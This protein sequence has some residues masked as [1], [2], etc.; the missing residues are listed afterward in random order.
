MAI[1]SRSMDSDPINDIRTIIGNHYNSNS[2]LKELI[3]NARDAGASTFYFKAIKGNTNADHELLKLDALLVFND[4]EFSDEDAAKITNIGSTHKLNSKSNVG[5]YGLG[6][7][8]IFHYCDAFFY[9]CKTETAIVNPWKSKHAKTHQDWDTATEKDDDFLNKLFISCQEATKTESDKG[10][11]LFIPLRNNSYNHYISKNKVEIESLWQPFDSVLFKKSL[12][13]ILGVLPCTIESNLNKIIIDT[14][15]IK[16]TIE[17]NSISK[18]HNI[19]SVNQNEDVY[20]VYFSTYEE[21]IYPRLKE[22]KET[23]KLP[24]KTEYDEETDTEKMF[25]PYKELQSPTFVALLHKNKTTIGTTRFQ[26]CCYLPL[27]DN[28]QI[29]KYKNSSEYDCDIFI[30][31]EFETDGGRKKLLGLDFSKDRIS[32]PVNQI[33][34]NLKEDEAQYWWNISLVQELLSEYL[35]T[36]LENDVLAYVKKNDSIVFNYQNFISDVFYKNSELIIP[37]YFLYKVYNKNE[38]Q[39]N[40]KNIEEIDEFY[41]E[42][43]KIIQDK[44]VSKCSIKE[45]YNC[46]KEYIFNNEKYFSLL[47]LKKTL[48]TT[49]ITFNSLF[50]EE[51]LLHLID[52]IL[53]KRIPIIFSPD[54]EIKLVLNNDTT[55]YLVEFFE[56]FKN[57]NSCECSDILN[58]FELNKEELLNLCK[59][60]NTY[61]ICQVHN[62]REKNP[63]KNEYLTYDTLTKICEKNGLYAGYLQNVDY[64]IHNLLNISESLD[65]YSISEKNILSKLFQD[66]EHKLLDVNKTVDIF[67][68]IMS[69]ESVNFTKDEILL[70]TFFSKIDSYNEN[71]PDYLS[72][73]KFIITN[74]RNKNG[75]LIYCDC[76]ESDLY[77]KLFSKSNSEKIFITKPIY[78]VLKQKNITIEKIDSFT[79]KTYLN[80]GIDFSIFTPDEKERFLLTLTGET[81]K[82][83]PLH[84]TT[85]NDYV[86]FTDFCYLIVD[87]TIK[88][89]TDYHNED[90]SFIK[91]SDNRELQERQ[92]EILRD[93]ILTETKALEILF[94][95]INLNLTDKEINAYLVSNINYADITILNLNDNFRNRKWIELSN[96]DFCSPNEIINLD[97][98]DKNISIKSIVG[99]VFTIEDISKDFQKLTNR[100]VFLENNDIA[101]DVL[102]CLHPRKIDIEEEQLLENWDIIKPFIQDKFYQLV[103]SIFENDKRKR[104]E[105]LLN[106]KY[107]VEG[108]FEDYANFITDLSNSKED[109]SILID[110]VHL[111]LEKEIVQE[112]LQSFLSVSTLKLP[113]EN[114]GWN[115]ANTISNKFN[116]SFSRKQQLNQS[117]IDVIEISEE[118]KAYV[119]QE[120]FET[121][122]ATEEN[123]KTFFTKIIESKNDIDP[124]L[125]GLFLFLLA[126]NYR[127]FAEN[128]GYFTDT[129]KS[130]LRENI[131]FYG[132]FTPEHWISKCSSVSDAI[133][134][135][136]N[137]HRFNVIL[138]VRKGK[139]IQTK[140]L[141]NSV[142]SVEITNNKEGD[143]LSEVN[144]QTP[145]NQT[146]RLVL[147]FLYNDLSEISSKQLKNAIQY[148]YKA[149]YYQRQL[150]DDFYEKLLVSEQASIECT[151]RGIFKEIFG[152]LKILKLKEYFSKEFDDYNE[153]NFS[154]HNND[155]Q[156][157]SDLQKKI[158]DK[159]N[160]A[161]KEKILSAV[162]KNLSDNQYDSTRILYE[163]LQ[164]ADDAVGQQID[165]LEKTGKDSKEVIRDF[166]IEKK[167]DTFIISHYGREINFRPSEQFPNSY[168]YDL[169]NMIQISNSDKPEQMN[170]TGKFGLGFKS[171]Y[172][173]CNQ[174]IIRSGRL[175]FQIIAGL[176]PEKCGLEKINKG[177]TRIE[178]KNDRSVSDLLSSFEK[179]IELSIIFSK[180][181]RGISLFGT[182]YLWSPTVTKINDNIRIEESETF[183]AIRMPD[184]ITLVFQNKENRIVPLADKY[185]KIWHTAPLVDE[186]KYLPYAVN[187]KF[188]VDTGRKSLAKGHKNDKLILDTADIIAESFVELYKQNVKNIGEMVSLILTSGLKSE[189]ILKPFA[190]KLC[191]RLYSLYG[192]IPDGYNGFASVTTTSR[193]FSISETCMENY[194]IESKYPELVGGLK[195]LLSSQ[196]R[197][198]LIS[199][200]TKSLCRD[201][202]KKY[203]V[204]KENYTRFELIDY[205]YYSNPEHKISSELFESF[206][207]LGLFELANDRNE[208]LNE[209]AKLLALDG[210]WYAVKDVF[211]FFIELDNSYKPYL[212]ELRCLI[213]IK[214]KTKLDYGSQNDFGTNGTDNSKDENNLSEKEK[215]DIEFDEYEPDKTIEELYDWWHSKT[216]EERKA[217]AADYYSNLLPNS[218]N[219]E[220]FTSP[221]IEL[222]DAE[223][224][225][226]FILAIYQS[227][228]F[229]RDLNNKTFL[230]SLDKLDK[231]GKLLEKLGD[232]KPSKNP[233]LWIDVILDFLDEKAYDE[234]YFT[235]FNEFPRMIEMSEFKD[236]YMQVLHDLNRLPEKNKH[237]ILT[238]ESLN[239][240]SGS[241]LR[242]APTIDRAIRI[243]F[244]L[245]IRELIRKNELD[246]VPKIEKFAFMPKTKCVKFVLGRAANPHTTESADL[247]KRIVEEI[248]EEKARF[249]GYYDIPLILEVRPGERS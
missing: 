148:V 28:S 94:D 200:T 205:L 65:V 190:E 80:S 154:E 181:I 114:G 126:G 31:S 98:S 70:S 198:I 18:K 224:F 21:K 102:L 55:K 96:G 106:S 128:N 66:D 49:N 45:T 9:T 29:M 127:S 13:D 11:M 95:D 63:A 44:L 123:I 26:F 172:F 151:K 1:N 166:I 54:Y 159:E 212:S 193:I 160:P 157:I 84:L 156:I 211:S 118:D 177:E 146:P 12:V 245:I 135:N 233:Q 178:L 206:I 248:G 34:E 139:T 32:F 105:F 147:Q 184:D 86:S 35:P 20:D 202:I 176:Y 16:T 169:S 218:V 168:K 234:V 153:A 73:I 82:R 219:F 119:D 152:T 174:P 93:S 230:N 124:R 77:T 222:T 103:D 229:C 15:Q 231:E 189:D 246:A 227:K 110:L 116:R 191:N 136:N 104:H 27:D 17:L 220:D 236:V 91:L 78:N 83:V 40:K 2:I 240:Y 90:I 89:P 113:T 88:L 131:P 228:P 56:P 68:T 192:I 71:I 115:F 238:P 232:N 242:K 137:P 75:N 221:D 186:F 112:N 150:L 201:N 19:I 120:N 194:V 10:F 85:T 197:N 188:E 167:S 208:I 67:K 81:F 140:N 215:I 225:I 210:N 4:G 22:I 100:K 173:L 3:Q 58:S 97:S 37:R 199:D 46:I 158:C 187:C 142:I 145:Y 60:L 141:C 182:R 76:Q 69:S 217:A 41:I 122:D 14:P 183:T 111:C 7:K 33:S 226:L 53:S 180:Y 25:S 59:K 244:S 72:V 64:L 5:K 203:L 237:E 179:N 8:S 57:S 243:G 50:T 165:L 247:Y 239:E 149:G 30:H 125:L 121:I 36:F 241:S 185:Q 107:V 24:E 48:G 52:K 42:V 101:S 43:N 162:R 138:Q 214:Q 132:D 39:W 108:S 38:P 207:K 87:E 133:L 155:K 134:K 130:V 171:V 92:K 47:G 161:I 164:N 249:D 23:G 163:L 79:V 74:F 213:K 117:L 223:W 144:L 170:A 99:T 61:P 209:N 175:Q 216:D 6:M 196:E 51:K 109:Y 129:D 204:E 143:I 62:I 235:W 195:I